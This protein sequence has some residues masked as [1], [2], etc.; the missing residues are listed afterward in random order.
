MEPFMEH[1][2]GR[3][4]EIYRPACIRSLSESSEYRGHLFNI[5]L[6]GALLETEFAAPSLSAVEIEINGDWVLAWAVQR[7]AGRLAVEWLEFGP[8]AVVRLLEVEALHL[9]TGDALAA[10]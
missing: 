8:S 3:R 5:S 1:R 2:H 10:A 7:A 4:V 6:S 9:S